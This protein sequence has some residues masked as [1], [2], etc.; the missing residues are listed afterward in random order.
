MSEDLRVDRAFLD[1][2]VLINVVSGSKKGKE[3]L[4]LL[5][6]E[7]FEIYI[8][9]KSIYEIYSLLK[10]IT[11]KKTSKHPLKYLVPKEL[12]DIAQKIFKDTK[13]DMSSTSYYW[14]NMSEE[15]SDN[16]NLSKEAKEFRIWKNKIKQAFSKVNKAIDDSGLNICEYIHLYKSKWYLG[17]GFILEQ[18]LAWD[19]LIPNEDFELI[20][21]ALYLNTRVFITNDKDIL[22]QGGL[23]LGLNSSSISFCSQKSLQQA[24]NDKFSQR[25]YI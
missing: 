6:E 15:W 9:S 7:G 22:K 8:F 2:N 14:Y 5:K 17:E 24:I 1:T 25:V 16:E 4:S 20:L 11:K 13:I 12:N 10:G 3:M 19:S 23:S 21:A 18:N